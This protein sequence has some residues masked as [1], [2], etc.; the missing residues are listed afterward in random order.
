LA[1]RIQLDGTCLLLGVTT[2]ASLN[3]YRRW[4]TLPPSAGW[5][6]H[7][8][9]TVALD[10]WIAREE[11]VAAGAA[12]AVD[13]Q[14][15]G[16]PDRETLVRALFQR[17]TTSLEGVLDHELDDEVAPYA[18]VRTAYRGAAAHR[19]ADWRFLQR[20]AGDPVVVQLTQRQHE[21]VAGRAGITAPEVAAV[22]ADVARV[23]TAAIGLSSRARR[24]RVPR[25]LARRAG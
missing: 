9:R 7:R 2:P 8:T 1:G 18:A 22:A 14:L 3:S 25:V 13:P 23:D 20:E 24:R 17:F 6:E 19:P 15:F 5:S 21:R 11:A 16:L 4:A 12:A 10:G